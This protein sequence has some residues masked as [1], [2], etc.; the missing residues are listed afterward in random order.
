MSATTN[1]VTPRKMVAVD[2]LTG[3]TVETLLMLIPSVAFIAYRFAVGESSFGR[4]RTTDGLLILSGLLTVVPLL[5]YTLSIRRIP[6]LTQAFIQFVSPTVQFLLAVFYMEEQMPT[7][8]W[9]AIVCVWIAMLVFIA[10]A[11]R[12][13]QVARRSRAAAPDRPVAAAE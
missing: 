8:R 5:T 1:G 10:D 13:A 4:E 11:A 6:L 7:A 3:L 12:A 2:S 9:A